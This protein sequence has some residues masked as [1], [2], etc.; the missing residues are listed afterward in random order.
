MLPILSGSW[1]PAPLWNRRRR[2]SFLPGPGPGALA[3]FWPI[4]GIDAA[5]VRNAE[6]ADVLGQHGNFLVQHGIGVFCVHGAVKGFGRRF[7]GFQNAQLATGYQRV[8]IVDGPATDA[9]PRDRESRH[10][11]QAVY[12]EQVL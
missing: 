3:S 6:I 9:E 11:Q 12:G 8:E 7:G 4:S 1:T 2:P 10:G 5:A